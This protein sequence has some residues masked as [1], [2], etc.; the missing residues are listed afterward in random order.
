[1]LGT[2]K[3]WDFE[4]RQLLYCIRSPDYE[5]KTLV[6]S[7][8]GLRLFDIRDQK[9][10]VWEPAAL[11]RKSVSDN[12]R[13][14][15]LVAAGG[16]ASAAVVG[17]SDE[18]AEITAV[19]APLTA[20]CLFIGKE[21]GSVSSYSE[22]SGLLASVLYTQ[23]LGVAIENMAWDRQRS[24]I[25]TA[26]MMSNVQIWQ[27]QRDQDYAG[28]W[29]ATERI[30]EFDARRVINGVSFSPDGSQ[31]LLLSTQAAAVYDM[32][33]H[34]QPPLSS[35]NSSDHV[36]HIWLGDHSVSSFLAV[37]RQGCIFHYEERTAGNYEALGDTV[38]LLDREGVV[39]SG[40]IEKMLYDLP[41]CLM[42]T[43]MVASPPGAEES[44]LLV[45]DTQSWIR[46]DSASTGNTQPP[47]AGLSKS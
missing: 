28:K 32:S 46:N 25:A 9:S 43:E 21:D 29:R 41:S 37:S 33:S 23:K 31:L 1:M 38:Q 30:V 42:A 6:F 39:F 19:I 14:N 15:E 8:D 27:L 7:G 5:V 12:S 24:L 44:R 35:S 20:G 18:V 3:L 11:V 22:S 45:Y 40:T 47:V 13:I 4:T 2:I 34:G 17:S 16:A 10:K 26:D 36:G